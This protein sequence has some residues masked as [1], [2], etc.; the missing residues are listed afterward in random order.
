MD[1]NKGQILFVT[2]FVSIIAL[3]ITLAISTNYI[4]SLRSSTL[5]ADDNK[6]LYAAE[7]LAEKLLSEDINILKSYYDNNNCN[8]SCVYT[9]QDGSIA[10][11]DIDVIGESNTL[12][13]KI[14]ENKY[15]TINLQDFSGEL[16]SVCFNDVS[17]ISADYTYFDETTF[18]MTSHFFKSF[19]MNN[20]TENFDITYYNNDY[21]NCYDIKTIGIP[22]SLSV[23][24]I[25]NNIDITIK[26]DNTNLIPF[27]GVTLTI[28]GRY[29]E[30]TNTIQVKKYINSA[31]DSFNYSLINYNELEPLLKIN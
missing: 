12:S 28:T 26:S 22:Y 27:N 23:K 16:I 30:N 8:D 6:A 19:D 13:L 14:K 20:E 17:S 11:A 29:F 18:K 31:I 2:L 5:Q 4:Y 7:S 3:S 1:N 24:S 21:G 25:Y 9:N 15:E 10:Y